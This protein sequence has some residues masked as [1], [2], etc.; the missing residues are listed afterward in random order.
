MSTTS[1]ITERVTA[2]DW[3]SLLL[4]VMKGCVLLPFVSV[5]LLLEFCLPQYNHHRV[6]AFLWEQLMSH[7][8][9]L[10]R[11]SRRYMPLS[12]GAC[13]YQFKLPSSVPCSFC[14]TI[15][16]AP[17]DNPEEFSKLLDVLAAHKV[18]ATFFCTTT[19][20]SPSMYG[21]MRRVVAEG[22]EVAN[23]MPED[24][25]YDK[26]SNEMFLA[27]LKE[28]E[29]VLSSYSPNVYLPETSPFR[30]DDCRSAPFP[31]RLFRPPMGR[32]SPT[33]TAILKT[34]NYYPSI[35]GDVFSNDPFVGGL[36]VPASKVAVDYHVK[37]TVENIVQGSI[38][39]FHCPKGNGERVQV[40]DSLRRIL[41]EM[42]ANRGWKAGTV[43]DF[44]A[45]E[46]ADKTGATRLEDIDLDVEKRR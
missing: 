43:G 17:G 9:P 20:I 10:I 28:S 39:V 1:G 7:R 15:D 8:W 46:N 6:R 44:I 13:V 14:L 38:V 35:L 4:L 19:T 21:A 2:A 32:Q 42:V 25:R 36:I 40:V 12:A 5:L 31:C 41:D 22:H 45:L 24:R 3:A 23:H 29:A 34:R 27:E 30:S 11:L 33:M 16:D 37:Y 18:R 26:F